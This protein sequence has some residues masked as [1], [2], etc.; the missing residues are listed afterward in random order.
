M[1]KWAGIALGLVI[2]IALI[3]LYMS[4]S[5]GF[6]TAPTDVV[7]TQLPVV[8]TTPPTQVM[9]PS[10]VID[11][12]YTSNTLAS[13]D[14]DSFPESMSFTSLR[15]ASDLSEIDTPS[16]PSFST[17]A[18]FSEVDTTAPT[19]AGDTDKLVKLEGQAEDIE[20]ETNTKYSEWSP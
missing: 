10:P 12:Q 11:H 20:M 6:E 3:V 13:T 2:V 4:R 16:I 5:S 19:P 18:D 15:V 8:P 14:M 9:E 7:P 1:H 17:N